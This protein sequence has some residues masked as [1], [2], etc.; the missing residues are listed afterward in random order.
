MKTIIVPVTLA[1]LND[2]D[3]F[4]AIVARVDAEIAVTSPLPEVQYIV[5]EDTPYAPAP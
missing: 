5:V 1:Q 2:D 4:A 3:A